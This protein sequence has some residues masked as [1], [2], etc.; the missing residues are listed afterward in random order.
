[1][2]AASVTSN[3][4]VSSGENASPDVCFHCGQ[5]IPSGVS[6]SVPVEGLPRRLCCMGCQAV[7]QSIVDNGLTE[8]YRH[9]NALPDQPVEALPSALQ[10]LGLFDHPEFQKTFV[11]PL[12][13]GEREADLILEGITCAACVWLNEKHLAQMPGVLG[14]QVNYATRRARVR[15]RESE[16]RL[17]QILAGVAAIGYRAHPF[18]PEKSERLAHK[19]RRSALWRLFVA[20][21]GMMQVMMYAYP[22]YVAGEGDMSANMVA[23]MRWASLVLTTPVVFYSAAPF[24]QRAWRD[25]RIGRVGMDVP[26]AIGVGSAYVASAWATVWAG[27]EVF[28][29]SVTMFVFFL[30]GGRFLEMLARQ[31]ASRGG[32]ELGRLTPAFARRLSGDGR[33]EERV[34]AS[35][36]VQGDRLLVRPGEVVVADGKVVAGDGEVD[37]SWL[38]GESR[39]Q[40]KKVGDVALGGSVNGSQP[41]EIEALHVGDA[42]RI[43][44]IR[45]LMERAASER[46][47]VVALA[48]KVAMRFTVAL[49]VVAVLTGIYWW[50]AEPARALEVFVS[51]LVV[52]CPCALSLATPAALTVAT[53]AFVRA[54][55]LVTRGHAIETL[56][57]A[58]HFVFD[59]TGT[60][61][62][63]AL[64]VANVN[65][66][67]VR[68]RESVLRI[69]AALELK[70][71]HSI[72]RAL[73]AEM[74]DAIAASDVLVVV[75]QGVRGEVGGVTY[76][77]GRLRFVESVVGV[78]LPLEEEGDDGSTVI[79]LGQ[80]GE[81]LA[82]IALKD[83]L[84]PD[85]TS[86]VEGLCAEGVRLSIFSGDGF[87][88]VHGVANALGVED[89]RGALTPEDKHE[90]L[91][92]LQRD[93]VVVM[94]GDGVNDAPVL[95][96]AHLSVAMSGGTE[97]ARNQADI[98]L[99]NDRLQSLL[100][101]RRLA[102][103]TEAV[104]RQN[105]G[106]AFAYNLLSIPAA[107]A[108]WVTPWIAGVGMG[109]SSLLVVLNAL[110]I[111]RVGRKL[112]SRLAMSDVRV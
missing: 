31:R 64:K 48:D 52:S 57:K 97:L 10:D 84:R 4:S 59:K 56:A 61:T 14:V 27:G 18:D 12:E 43:A 60:L 28:F 107:M 8:Y 40:F 46:P 53:D 89:A 44:T 6:L 3:A 105:L 71:E 17:S 76:V 11:R 86:L 7:C 104:I 37:E 74:P 47:K 21:F 65:C 109:L 110:R 111:G 92:A 13:G 16:I 67:G 90:A 26:V 5:L 79:Y 33:V 32:E 68:S 22:E 62:V 19:E 94:V 51:V 1:M 30:L 93:R 41:L 73:V 9:R 81:W 63:G 29:D 108:G 25:L 96:G 72:A 54:G 80:Q 87:G 77:L 20:G 23:I 112:Q 58:S 42:T 91:L 49:L 100:L 34:P 101:G 75:G 55:L 70:S 85:A 50:L 24:F 39:P 106:W 66:Y 99:L 35:A 98:V 69:A 88:A 38:T 82:S 95:A 83:V 2:S 45:R 103:Q 78:A 102:R 15:W 36:V